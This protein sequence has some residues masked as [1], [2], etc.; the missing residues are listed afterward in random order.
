MHICTHALER[1]HASM[2]VHPL[3]VKQTISDGWS[4][5]T[6]EEQ[7]EWGEVGVLGAGPCSPYVSRVERTPLEWFRHVG[8]GPSRA[9]CSHRITR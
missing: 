9:H 6:R 4:E 8:R 3:Q 5:L 1:P 2:N 7:Q